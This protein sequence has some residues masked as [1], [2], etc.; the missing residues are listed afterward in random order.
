MRSKSNQ[1]TP[2]SYGEKI[3]LPQPARKEGDGVIAT[4]VSFTTKEPWQLCTAPALSSRKTECGGHI[5]EHAQFE[6]H[7]TEHAHFEVIVQGGKMAGGW[8]GMPCL[9]NGDISKG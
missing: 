6:R 8:L 3:H 4:A 2:G 9:G 5:C 7:S 1:A